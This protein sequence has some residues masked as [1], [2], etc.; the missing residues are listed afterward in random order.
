MPQ[1]LDEHKGY[2]DDPKQLPASHVPSGEDGDLQY[3]TY[4]CSSCVRGN[5][6]IDFTELEVEIQHQWRMQATS[7][8]HDESSIDPSVPVPNN[9][10]GT[11]WERWPEKWWAANKYKSWSQ[12][13]KIHTPETR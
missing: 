11:I 2:A 13:G 7:I 4:I 3:Y 12:R 1:I 9:S 6:K 5:P 10:R 8:V